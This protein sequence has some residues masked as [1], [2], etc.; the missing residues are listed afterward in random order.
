MCFWR[1]TTFA[2]TSAIAT[3]P[4]WRAKCPQTS[5]WTSGRA[6]PSPTWRTSPDPAPVCQSRWDEPP[7]TRPAA[8]SGCLNIQ[9]TCPKPQV[10]TFPSLSLRPPL[11]VPSER[12]VVTRARWM[13]H[14]SSGNTRHLW[15]AF[16]QHSRQLQRHRCAN[17]H[18]HMH[19]H[20]HTHALTVFHVW[21]N[22]ALCREAAWKVTK[23][24]ITSGSAGNNTYTQPRT[25]TQHL[26]KSQILKLE[27]YLV[28]VWLLASYVKIKNGS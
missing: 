27:S 10:D 6:A 28:N 26:Q 9:H 15:P 23:T 2:I 8:A 24:C 14:Y 25:H 21:K 12:I 7:V 3:S 4:A 22:T 18:A 19:S 5:S 1:F 13:C 20:T 16:T 17:A 11:C